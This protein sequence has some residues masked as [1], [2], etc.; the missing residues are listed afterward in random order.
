MT[1]EQFVELQGRHATVHE[2]VHAILR[3]PQPIDDVAD[4]SNPLR[5][6]VYRD[7]PIYE[8]LMIY[9]GP[10]REALINYFVEKL[11]DP[12]KWL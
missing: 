11:G 12:R 2:V 1:A 7:V 3:H 9:A 10:H 5:L 4:Q 8:H 6:P